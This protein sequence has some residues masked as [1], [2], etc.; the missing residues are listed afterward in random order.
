MSGSL[1]IESFPGLFFFCWLVLS[2]FEVV[3]L[4]YIIIFYFYILIK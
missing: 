4:L 3:V 2:N 1:I